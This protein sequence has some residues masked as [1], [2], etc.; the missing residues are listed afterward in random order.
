LKQIA[1][2][3]ESWNENEKTTTVAET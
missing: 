3:V 2:Q 1:E